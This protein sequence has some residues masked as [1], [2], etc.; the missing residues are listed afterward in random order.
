MESISKILW[1][2]HEKAR[3]KTAP[4]RQPRRT[5]SC[6]LLQVTFLLVTAVAVIHQGAGFDSSPYLFGHNV[7]SSL[8]VILGQSGSGDVYQG[9]QRGSLSPGTPPNVNCCWPP[10]QSAF[11][12]LLPQLGIPSSLIVTQILRLSFL[13]RYVKKSRTADPIFV[14]LSV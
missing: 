4:M 14:K 13:A 12:A 8:G 5:A 1:L 7:Q 10:R 3:W 2:L 9:G 11:R 6:S